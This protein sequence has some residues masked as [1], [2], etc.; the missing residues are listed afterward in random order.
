MDKEVTKAE[1][2]S[3]C[4]KIDMDLPLILNTFDEKKIII[5]RTRFKILGAKVPDFR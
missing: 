3:I 1:A 5:I 4:N 2:E